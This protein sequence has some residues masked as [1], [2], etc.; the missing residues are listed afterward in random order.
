MP[1]MTDDLEVLEPSGSSVTVR[2]EVLDLKPLTI[3][4]LPKLVRTARPVIDA[5]FAIAGDPNS[6]FVDDTINAVTQSIPGLIP[7][8]QPPAGYQPPDGD[9]DLVVVLLDLIENHSD[10]VF[11]AAE[12]C[13]GK[14][15]A[16]LEECQID[17]FVVLATRIYEVNRDFF[18][19]K[20]APR[21][22]A[23]R[24]EAG[25]GNVATSGPGLTASSS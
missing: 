9:G 10:C 3:G 16:W 14:P 4:Q 24:P 13:T 22:A 6:T 1:A 15:A 7:P 19:L 8:S 25:A 20:L 2:D 11:N 21:L 5:L 12:I 23:L 17:E 18:V